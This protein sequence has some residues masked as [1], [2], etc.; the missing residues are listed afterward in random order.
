MVHTVRERQARYA[1]EEAR[2]S[3]L[4]EPEYCEI[5]Y[6]VPNRDDIVEQIPYGGTASLHEPVELEGYTFLG[7]ENA[8]G[9]LET[10]SSFPVWQ[11]SYYTAHYTLPLDTVNH[12]PYL[13]ADRNGV[14]DVDGQVSRSEFVQ[15]IYKLLNIDRVG[16][17][18]FADVKSSDPCYKAAATLKDLGILQGAR[19]YPNDVLTQLDMLEILE[20]FYPVPDEIMDFPDLDPEG[21]A[22]PIYSVAAVF[23]WI[24]PADPADPSAPVTRGEM[25]R[26][27]NRVL[28]RSFPSGS[29]DSVVGTI[30][31]VPPT[32][33]YYPDIAEAVIPHTYERVDSLEVWTASKPLPAHEPGLFFAGV[34]LHYIDSDGRHALNTE[35]D[36]RL[37]N[38]RG[39]LTSGDAELDELLWAILGEIV[40][41][42][43]MNAEEMLA[44]VYN[45][46]CDNFSPGVDTLY[47]VGAEGWAAK[48][49][50]RFLEN[51]G[52]S[53]YGY[54]A[55]FYELAYFVG[56]QPSLYSGIIY[57]TQ[58]VFEAED[59]SWIEAPKGY[60]PH[61]WVEITYE[62]GIPYIFD[63]SM[64][65]RVDRN[66]SFFKV[67]HPIRYRFGYRTAL[68]W[69]YVS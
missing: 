38:D 64:E 7:W 46:V 22:Y 28:G 12:I 59:G 37:Y 27:I 60:I 34:R 18:I 21:E 17:G 36:G 61:A 62:D 39:E 25:A 42:D 32:H 24:D 57:G 4:V 53:S 69:P 26:V 47:E 14:V 16:S 35:V 19:L 31:D 65:S 1:A 54:A 49:A 51:K 20:R 33:P 9:T 66:R 41:P 52:G 58:T 10:R 23:G 40:D 15:I 45:Y 67:Y 55:L 11:D 30:L 3:L 63:P 29:R 56:Y 44:A 6:L 50:K 43:R 13:S 68:W 48:E 5:R 8:D 2:I